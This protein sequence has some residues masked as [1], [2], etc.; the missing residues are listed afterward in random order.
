V[1]EGFVEAW[2]CGDAACEAQIKDDTKATLRCIP[3]EQPSETGKCIR[4][5]QEADE[6]AV[7]ARAY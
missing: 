4:C 2:W 3:L 1:A 6:R 5:D 7:F